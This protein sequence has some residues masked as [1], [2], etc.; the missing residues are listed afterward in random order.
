LLRNAVAVMREQSSLRLVLVGLLSWLIWGL[1]FLAAWEGFRFL[2]FLSG[3]QMLSYREMFIGVMFD[4]LFLALAL[5]LMFSGSIIVYRLLQGVPLEGW[6][7]D[8]ARNQISK[9]AFARGVL[10]P[11][12]WMSLGL[13][14]A[15]RGRIDEAFYRLAQVWSNGLVLY[16]I[17][18]WLAARYYRRGY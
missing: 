14:E 18:T 17:T 7:R 11:T 8:E 1:I 12:H 9:L 6:T 5:M 2:E 13:Q 16:L 3:H 4:M 10:L 15:G